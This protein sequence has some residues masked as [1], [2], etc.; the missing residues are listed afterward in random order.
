MYFFTIVIHTFDTS[1]YVHVIVII[2]FSDYILHLHDV[3]TWEVSILT[4]E[5]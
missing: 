4:L 5:S 2:T 1:I 3:M